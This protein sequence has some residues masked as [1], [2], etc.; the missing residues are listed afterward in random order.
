MPG[1]LED[2]AQRGHRWLRFPRALEAQFQ[3]DTL[4]QRRIF[5]AVCG[6]IGILGIYLGAVNVEKLMPDAAALARSNV[7]ICIVSGSLTLLCIL[8]LPK[9]LRR[10]WQAEAATFVNTFGLCVAIIYGPMI[11]HTDTA[12]TQSVALI[13][14]VMYACIAARLRFVWAFACGVL[15]LLGYV[16]FVQGRTPLQELIVT[17]NIKLLA[18]SF[19]F[20]LVANYA[21]EYNERRN[22]VLRKLQ[23]KQR[24][25]LQETSQRLHRLSVQDPLTGLFNRRQFDTDLRLA[26]SQAEAA[27]QPLALLMLDVDFFKRYNDTYGHPAGD[28]CLMQVADVLSKVAQEHGGVAARLGGEEFSL[29]LPGAAADRAMAAAQDLCAR[30]R[31]ARIEHR[32]STVSAHVSI[33]VGV[34]Q[35]LPAPGLNPQTLIA[36]ADQ[37]LYQ[38]K[39]AGRDRATAAPHIVQAAANAAAPAPHVGASSAVDNPTPS[40]DAAQAEAPEAVYLRLLEGKFRWLSFPA[41]LELDYR[42]QSADERRKHLAAMA[43]LGLVIF[44]AFVLSNRSMFPDISSSVLMA[45]VWLSAAMLAI[46][47]VL[48]FVKTLPAWQREASFSFGTAVVAVVSAW[49]LSQSRQTTAL[50]FCLSL[51]LVPMFS[52]VG[53]RQPFWF[54]CVPAVITIAAVGALFKP[55]GPEQ[56]VVFQQ[57]IFQIIN[58]TCYTLILAYTLDYG[59]RKAW[60][61]SHIERLQNTALRHSTRALRRLSLLDPLTGVCNRRQFESDFERIWHDGLKDCRPVAMLIVD[62][63][64]FKLYNDGYGHPAG[65]RCLKQVASALGAAAHEF[66]GLVARLGGEEFGILLPSGDAQK[67]VALGERVCAAVRQMGIEHRHSKAGEHV[68][69]SVGAA[70]LVPD[71]NTNRRSLLSAADDALYRAKTTGRNRVVAHSLPEPALA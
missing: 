30:V 68:T 44:N 50:S 67:A 3:A 4:E 46:T 71:S 35:A 21:I 53:A 59:A 19:A 2:V 27:Q 36:A 1:S 7:N 15:S 17:S 26:W 55:V 39:E 18:L 65:D 62:V 42:L 64:F 57:S 16:I 6:V 51:V 13:G 69:V 32:G 41:A 37:A 63:D 12:V 5:L 43:V 34:A 47:A 10:T 14:S 8:L 22:W 58:I 52:G 60:L 66:K 33:S 40:A 29:L 61:L 20:V 25:V 28:A 48:F 54:T 56:T 38:A 24:A 9:P 31:A 11:S 23:E 49:V 45:Q 70:S